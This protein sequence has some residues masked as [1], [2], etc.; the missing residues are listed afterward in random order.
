M[1]REHNKETTKLCVYDASAKVEGPS[2]NDSLLVGPPLHRKLFDILLNFRMYRIGLIAD[3][4]KAFLMICIAEANQDALR[5]LWCF[6]RFISNNGTFKSASKIL[7]F[8]LKNPEVEQFL[9]GVQVKWNFNIERAPRWGGFFER[10]IQLLKRCL[11]KM[12]GHSKLMYE[13]LLTEVTE[14]ELILNSRPLTY[15]SPDDLEEHITPS[16]LMTGR[17]LLSLPDHLR[18]SESEYFEI[19]SSR[20]TISRRLQQLSRILDHFWTQRRKEYLVELRESHKR[21]SRGDGDIA[22][23]GD[24]VIIQDESPQGFWRLGL[25]E[26]IRGEDGLERGAIVRVK[27]GSGPSAFIRRPLQR[28]FPLQVPK[29]IPESNSNS[30]MAVEQGNT[31]SDFNPDELVNHN[32]IS[33]PP[34]EGN[35]SVEIP[36]DTNIGVTSRPRRRAA[37]EA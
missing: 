18:Y 35:R 19:K 25:I 16:H 37:T 15:L 20:L 36:D 8:I 23:L 26:D 13:E 9:S 6:K 27:S 32:V 28:L 2:L 33:D 4:E 22:S 34:A 11:K 7:K 31:S 1:I 12:V 17:H 30:P 14:V 5:F 24:V 29:T 10:M 3:I 21:I